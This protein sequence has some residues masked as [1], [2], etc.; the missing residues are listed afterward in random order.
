MGIDQ[1]EFGASQRRCLCAPYIHTCAFV[2]LTVTVFGPESSFWHRRYQIT[3]NDAPIWMSLLAFVQS[4]KGNLANGHT[5]SGTNIA[6]STYKCGQYLDNA[7]RPQSHR[8]VC[9]V[10][11]GTDAKHR[12]MHRND[13]ALRLLS[14]LKIAASNCILLSTFQSASWVAASHDVRDCEQ[15][16]C[17]T[18]ISCVL[19]NCFLRNR[20]RYMLRALA[21]I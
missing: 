11:F 7:H 17:G 1:D 8:C 4:A 3:P 9:C 5:D 20:I 15:C 12:Q 16:L 6:F 14:N 13:V 18:R 19:R 2:G 21:I 10:P